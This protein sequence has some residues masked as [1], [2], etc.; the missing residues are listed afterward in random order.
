ME[1]TIEYFTYDGDRNTEKIYKII[2]AT[3]LFTYIGLGVWLAQYSFPKMKR[4]T[5]MNDESVRNMR[6]INKVNISNFSF[7]AASLTCKTICV[8]ILLIQ[9]MGLLNSSDT[10]Y[11]WVK[12]LDSMSFVLLLVACSLQLYKWILIILR[13]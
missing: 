1:L 6:D 5:D 10:S 9:A 8:L 4:V 3:S 2:L 13:V 12:V 7:L 11:K